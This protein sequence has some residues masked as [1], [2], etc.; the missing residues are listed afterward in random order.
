MGSPQQLCRL[1]VVDFVL[2]SL[3]GGI[4][5]AQYQTVRRVYEPLVPPTEAEA[6]AV[7]IRRSSVDARST[8]TL[9]LYYLSRLS[10]SHDDALMRSLTIRR[11]CV[12]LR[13]ISDEA[14]YQTW[15]M[16]ESLCHLQLNRSSADGRICEQ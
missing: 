5:T 13:S 7:L 11:A 10:R 8:V 15:Y 12:S 9:Y 6:D 16:I 2:P 1:S 4:K 14:L 3:T